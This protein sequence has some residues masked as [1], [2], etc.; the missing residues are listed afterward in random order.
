DGTTNLND[1]ATGTYTD[2]VTNIAIP[3]STTATASATVQ[4]SGVELNTS[5][6][7]N[8]LE[9]ITGAGFSYSTDS[10]S[11]ASGAFDLGYLAGTATTGSVSWT[12]ASQSGS[13]SATFS[14]TIYA[15]SGTSSSGTLSDTATLTG[16]DGFTTDAEASVDISA[17]AQ[18]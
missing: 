8:D 11:G 13:G 15:G 10:V 9:S 4:P 3:G 16:S 6:S 5:A 2:K 1:V 17:S 7:V 18:A 12:S 14:K